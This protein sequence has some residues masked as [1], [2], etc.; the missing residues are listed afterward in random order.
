MPKEELVIVSGFIDNV[1][2]KGKGETNIMNPEF[3][4]WVKEGFDAHQV[5]NG[6]P[7]Y[8]AIFVKGTKSIR[9]VMEIDHIDE[10]IIVPVGKPVP[11]YIPIRR[12]GKNKLR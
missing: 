7:Q 10:K 6:E 3:T 2:E 11:V 5:I 4:K 12:F 9:V 8:A 1:Y